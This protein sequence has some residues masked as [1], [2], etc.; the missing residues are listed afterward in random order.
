M[1]QNPL[2]L[3]KGC[4][5]T[6]IKSGHRLRY[7]GTAEHSHNQPPHMVDHVFIRE[8]DTENYPYHVN[9][10]NLLKTVRIEPK[11]IE[12]DIEDVIKYLHAIYL[13]DI[14]DFDDMP[15]YLKTGMIET[16][17][18]LLNQKQ[19]FT[20]ILFNLVP[21]FVEDIH[22]SYDNYLENLQGI[23]KDQEP[24]EIVD[25]AQDVIRNDRDD[26][27]ETQDKLQKV[28]HI[29]KTHT[30]Y[31]DNEVYNTDEFIEPDINR[32]VHTFNQFDELTEHYERCSNMCDEIESM[33]EKLQ[34][35]R[36]DIDTEVEDFLNDL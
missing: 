26:A 32:M 9:T 34:S 16:Q 4:R 5:F 2:L 18:V 36:D 31:L 13:I 35:I 30:K 10:Y 24:Q 29:T 27:K 28:L 12:L 19:A 15:D 22:H 7:E 23:D 14:D 3:L 21:A 25:D 11:D 20:F 17:N 8:G 6:Q 1:K 33:Q